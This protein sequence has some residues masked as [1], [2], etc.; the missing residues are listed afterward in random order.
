M[1]KN[2]YELVSKTLK[3][4]SLT[5]AIGNELVEK[6]TAFCEDVDNLT[7]KIDSEGFRIETYC[8]LNGCVYYEEEHIL[9]VFTDGTICE[10]KQY[11]EQEED[12][13]TVEFDRQG[14]II[15]Y[16]QDLLPD[17]NK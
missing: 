5:I 6:I 1:M 13:Y 10:F 16:L 14:T 7:L 11:K 4:T 3:N 17:F 2:L 9:S 8:K 12:E 15:E